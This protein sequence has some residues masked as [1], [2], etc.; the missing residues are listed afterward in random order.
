M[1]IQIQ[2]P[3]GRYSILQ[4]T[5]GCPTGMSSG[6]RFQD[7]KD[8]GKNRWRP[9]DIDNCIRFDKGRNFKTYYCTKTS[10]G[11]VFSWPQGKYCIARYGPRCPSGFFD[12]SIHWDD[13]DRHN[14]N[15]L[16]NPI[17]DGRYDINTQIQYCCRS[18]GNH[19]DPMR[20]PPTQ[21]FALYRYDGRCQRV[22]GI[23]D[24]IALFLHFDDENT[25]NDNA[26]SGNHPDGACVH[27]G[28]QELY[29]CYYSP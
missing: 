20:L 27:N 1:T 11:G 23:N 15:A 3:G 18:D 14:D 29:R 5:A 26:C 22:H 21:P 28:N 13:E 12:G 24:P 10:E 25:R 8:N 4:A 9:T 7:N 6:W 19:D 16:Q 2:W 17:P